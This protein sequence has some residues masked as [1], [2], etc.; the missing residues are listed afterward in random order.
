MLAGFR[1]ATLVAVSF[2]G[3]AGSTAFAQE[4]EKKYINPATNEVYELPLRAESGVANATTLYGI[5][6]DGQSAPAGEGAVAEVASEAEG[7]AGL[8][9]GV[10]LATEFPPAL[11]HQLGDVRGAL[12]ETVYPDS[13]AAE[14]GIEAYDLI[15]RVGEAD[16]DSHEKLIE[17]M[18][19]VEAKP[20][21]VV[22]LRGG[23][24]KT[25]VVTPRLRE[26]AQ[27]AATVIGNTNDLFFYN[28]PHMRVLPALGG[29]DA[30]AM[31]HRLV[32]AYGPPANLPE[33]V[34]SVKI[35]I[36][37]DG[38]KA[39]HHVEV[40]TVDGKMFTAANEEELNKFPPEIRAA[41]PLPLNGP[42]LA[43][44]LDTAPGSQEFRQR[45]FAQGAP[46]EGPAPPVAVP[47]PAP[48][49]P[50]VTTAAPWV[51]IVRLPAP[52][53]TGDVTYR[54]APAT[55]PGEELNVLKKELSDLR[56]AVERIEKLLQKDE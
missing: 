43:L 40:T 30:G 46:F 49:A 18:K 11:A 52:A 24:K 19:T 22:V 45:V 48:A 13:P 28:L 39:K 34:K 3:L 16:V 54:V 21:D 7:P 8:W 42:R 38:E 56:A 26:P 23:E 15:V 12:V 1:F 53:A 10:Q 14:S 51:D 33:N 9:L 55:P 20:I 5:Q 29:P 35:R 50:V 31:H 47:P 2:A 27:P 4:A 25:I 36:E 41:L 44:R 6:A 17:A 37:R 32:Q